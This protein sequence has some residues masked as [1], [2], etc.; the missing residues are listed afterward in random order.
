ME[1]KKIGIVVGVGPCAGL[2]LFKKVLNNT[3]SISDQQHLDVLLHSL[4]GQIPDRTAFLTGLEDENPAIGL[5]DV[6]STLEASSVDIIG[7]PC[8]TSHSAK[9]WRPLS[10]KIST[11]FPHIT[12]VNM[13]KEV[14]VAIER[15]HAR[16]SKIGII[17][18]YFIGR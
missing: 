9:I 7:I 15:N 6:V 17:R 5:F 2:D 1:N 8:N 11:G 10:E 4:P 14:S 12:L 13:I 18:F 16:N 3:H